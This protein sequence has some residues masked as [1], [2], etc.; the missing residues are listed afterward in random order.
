PDLCFVRLCRHEQSDISCYEG[1]MRERHVP[2]V[3]WQRDEAEISYAAGIRKSR[4]SYIE[5]EFDNGA[6]WR[7][8]RFCLESDA[9]GFFEGGDRFIQHAFCGYPF[10]LL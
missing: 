3:L 6:Y 4:D 9:E 8:F 7:Y 2:L 5:I 10:L 1:I